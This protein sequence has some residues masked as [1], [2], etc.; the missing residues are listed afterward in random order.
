[1]SAFH[2]RPQQYRN[3]PAGRIDPHPD[4]WRVHTP[5]QQSKLTSILDEN[6]FVGTILVRP[7]GKDKAGPRYQC[8]D[9][10]ERLSRF[11]ADEKV[12]CLIVKMSDEEAAKF[13]ATYDTITGLA[14]TDIE[15][16]RR[17]TA[18]IEWQHDDLDDLIT[19]TLA[20]A[21]ELTAAA[22]A[23][24]DEDYDEDEDQEDDAKPTGGRHKE[25][26]APDQTGQLTEL[27]QVLVTCDDEA[28]QRSF[29]ETMANEGRSAKALNT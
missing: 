23:D 17:L 15:A 5:D 18:G 13:L 24:G 9:G 21:E 25:Q 6:G 3:I 19:S 14:G 16:L 26:S 4:N 12:P 29:L 11:A 1:M 8:L 10:H 22:L 20:D 28:D 7:H 2:I 27:W